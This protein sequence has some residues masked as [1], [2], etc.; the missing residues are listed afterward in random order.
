MSR[1]PKRT[2][3]F[4]FSDKNIIKVVGKFVPELKNHAMTTHC[5]V[6]VKL[7]PFLL[8]ILDVRSHLHAPKGLLTGKEQQTALDVRLREP[9]NRCGRTR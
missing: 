6:E 8:S 9:Q 2:L 7:Q 3:L 5:E 4:W 1:S